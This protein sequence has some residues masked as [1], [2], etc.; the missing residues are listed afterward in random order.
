MIRLHR[1][2]PLSSLTAA[3]R[4]GFEARGIPSGKVLSAAEAPFPFVLPPSSERLFRGVLVHDAGQARHL[5]SVAPFF[6]IHGTG[7]L[8]RMTKELSVPEKA[9]VWSGEMLVR[10]DEATPGL[11]KMAVVNDCQISKDDDARPESANR[12]LV[13][14]LRQNAVFRAMT[15]G[16]QLRRY[17]SFSDRLD[18]LFAQMAYDQD[19]SVKHIINY[20]LQTTGLTADFIA[21]YDEGYLQLKDT[22]TLTDVSNLYED[23][24]DAKAVLESFRQLDILLKVYRNQSGD[25]SVTSMTEAVSLLLNG[26]GFTIDQLKV[27]S[28]EHNK[29]SSMFYDLQK[30][31]QDFDVI[32]FTAA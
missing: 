28:S 25:Q 14:V 11:G 23:P 27:F 24:E 13:A 17:E 31:D 32:E 9:I 20:I 5:L 30:A 1:P 21:D 3:N 29:V 19:G 6:G 10:R 22:Y 18:T 15:E 2:T 4:T 8:H 16:I 7:G 26:S 12:D